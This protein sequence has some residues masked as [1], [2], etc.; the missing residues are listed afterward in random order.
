MALA[1][2]HPHQCCFWIAANGRLHDIL[3][4]RQ[5]A[6]LRL[7]RKLAPATLAANAALGQLPTPAQFDQTATDGAAGNPCCKRHGGYAAS[8]CRLCLAGCNKAAVPFIQK[9][10][11]CRKAGFDSSGIN[12]QRRAAAATHGQLESCRDHLA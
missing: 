4:R 12:C 2:A 10:C 9:W 6:W 11:H 7:E 1:S 5:Q 3:K 8:T